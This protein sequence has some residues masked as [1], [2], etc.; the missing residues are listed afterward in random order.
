ML[1]TNSSSNIEEALQVL[2]GRDQQNPLST[3]LCMA[4]TMAAELDE[5]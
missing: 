5:R 2:P 4:Q 3:L 1:G